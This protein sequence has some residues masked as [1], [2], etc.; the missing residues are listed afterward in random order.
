MPGKKIIVLFLA[1][2]LP[3][4]I[5]V[6]LKVFGR[7][8]FDVPPLYQ[9]TTNLA[10]ESCQLIY[11][12]PYVLADSSMEKIRAGKK[13][14]LYLLNFSNDSSVLQQVTDDFSAAELTLVQSRR[15]SFEDVDFFKRCVLL[16]SPPKDLVLIDDEKRIRGY[17]DSSDQDEL[18]RLLDELAIILKKY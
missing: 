7:N 3:V 18:D 6:F 2:L 11:P 13:S 15:T 9:D 8:Q 17:Y 1:L 12:T 16:L 4:G 10:P 14:S 5:F